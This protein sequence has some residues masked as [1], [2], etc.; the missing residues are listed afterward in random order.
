MANMLGVGSK[1]Q[2]SVFSDVKDVMCGPRGAWKRKVLMSKS[3]KTD[4]GKTCSLSETGAKNGGGG[5]R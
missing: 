5:G 1:C 4:L 3:R 2:H